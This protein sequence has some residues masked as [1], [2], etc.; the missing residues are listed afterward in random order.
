M[1][2]WWV[3]EEEKEG[4]SLCFVSIAYLYVPN[5]VGLAKIQNGQA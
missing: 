2:K 3:T 1:K 4:F 5:G